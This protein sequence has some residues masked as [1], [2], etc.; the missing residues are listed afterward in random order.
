M[1]GPGPGVMRG[2]LAGDSLIPIVRSGRSR[3]DDSTSPGNRCPAEAG[4]GERSRRSDGGLGPST[5][6]DDIEL[7]GSFRRRLKPASSEVRRAYATLKSSALN[8]L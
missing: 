1:T 6:A 7:R 3:R 2:G 4:Q 5:L 8:A